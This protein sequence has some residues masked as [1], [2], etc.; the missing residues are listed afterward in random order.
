MRLMKAAKGFCEYARGRGL[1]AEVRRQGDGNY[2]VIVQPFE[3]ELQVQGT[4]ARGTVELADIKIR[5]KRDFG[6]EVPK[7][8][9]MKGTYKNSG[10]LRAYT[11]YRAVR[12]ISAGFYMPGEPYAD[13]HLDRPNER[14]YHDLERIIRKS[15][16]KGTFSAEYC[17]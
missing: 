7:R 15:F 10:V 11:D 17:T 12:R 3:S 4:T 6:K 9:L 5:V 2:I 13:L 14:I 1:S 8:I 16:G